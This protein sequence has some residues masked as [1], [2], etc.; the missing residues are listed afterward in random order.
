LFF[1]P[2][3]QD[4]GADEAEPSAA[5]AGQAA[6]QDTGGRRGGLDPAPA[7][8]RLPL[9]HARRRRGRRV[10]PGT[11]PAAAL[12]V[13]EPPRRW[14][15]HEGH[16][17]GGARWA[18]G[19]GGGPGRQGGAAQVLPGGRRRG[20]RGGGAGGGECGGGERDVPYSDVGR[21]LEGVP[22]WTPL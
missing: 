7:D 22:A 2:L 20:G 6:R 3:R 4:D 12:P 8:V 9:L 19:E 13:A 16:G 17:D 11:A 15:A 18:G 21:V 5:A 10:S 1:L 14:R